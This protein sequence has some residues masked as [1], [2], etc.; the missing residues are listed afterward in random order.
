MS[1]PPDQDVADW[2]RTHVPVN[3]VFAIDRWNGFMP[4]VFLPQQILT[5]SGLE[6][7]LPNEREIY[8]A[9]VRWYRTSMRDRGVQPF[10]NDRETA[11][12]RKAFLRELGATHVLLDPQY[13]WTLRPV[14][15]ALPRLFA[16]RFDNGRWAVYEVNQSVA[17]DAL[18]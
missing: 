11:T 17:G 18:D 2:V 13:Y 12:E 1:C 6:F 10:F 9:Y 3:A 4:T 15:D 14:L 8:P 5:F 16:R 7:S